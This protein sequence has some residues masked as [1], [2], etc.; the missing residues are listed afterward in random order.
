MDTKLIEYLLKIHKEGNITRAAEKLF[1]TQPALNQQLLKIEKELGTQLFY[2]NR[3]ELVPTKAGAVYLENAKN[4]LQI[5]QDTYRIINDLIESKKG[6]LSIGFTPGRGNVMFA[7]VYPNFHAQFPDVQVCPYEL[8]V[9]ELQK[10]IES[11]ELDIAFLTLT[12]SQKNGDNY[13]D[14]MKEKIVLA[15]PPNHKLASKSTFDINN[16]TIMD[17]V[18]VKDE[19]F[20]VMHKDSTLREITNS[21]FKES[22]QTPNILLETINNVTITSMVHSNLCCGILPYYYIKNSPFKLPIFELHSQPTWIISACYK[23]DSYMSEA[24]K[25]FIKLVKEFWCVTSC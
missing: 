18:E 2:R 3:N 5:K 4:M 7:N 14:L 13:I 8:K 9:A 6:T 17:I 10:K 20:V 11:G 22:K 12:E 24:G 16:L 23:K 19:P 1:I 21:I 15:I 25:C